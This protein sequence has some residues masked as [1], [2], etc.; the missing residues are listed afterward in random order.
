MAYPLS[1]R[2]RF[3]AKP[4]IGQKIKPGQPGKFSRPARSL[5]VVSRADYAPDAIEEEAD[6]SDIIEEDEAAA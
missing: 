5:R 2:S 6:V 1:A 3:D 4:G